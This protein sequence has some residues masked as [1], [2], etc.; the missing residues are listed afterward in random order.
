MALIVPFDGSSLSKTALV[1]A[2]QFDTVLKEGVV[3]VTAIP[4]NN[5]EYARERGWIDP[6]EPFDTDAVV[7]HLRNESEQIAPDAA[8][9]HRFVDRYAPPGTVANRI[10]KFA[11]TNDASI[12]FIGSE[13][14]GRFVSRF[15]VGTS[16]AADRAYDTMLI[17]NEKLPKITKLEDAAPAEDLLP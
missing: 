5:A 12:V 15:T 3:S 14:A 6:T 13:N 9:H 10:R 2:V 16:I 11:R 17:T 1:R 8:F 4:K 7:S